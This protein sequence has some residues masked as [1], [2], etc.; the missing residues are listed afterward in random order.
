M[1]GESPRREHI[2]SWSGAESEGVPGESSPRELISW[3][4]AAG[5]Y[6]RQPGVQEAAGGER[7][8]TATGSP[9]GSKSPDKHTWDSPSAA[10]VKMKKSMEQAKHRSRFET[11]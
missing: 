3:F 7:S 10:E 5:H 2:I 8:P 11:R 4:G 6:D 9:A 1:P